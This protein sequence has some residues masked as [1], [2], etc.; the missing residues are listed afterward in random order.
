MQYNIKHS[1][2][3]ESGENMKR[4]TRKKEDGSYTFSQV[5]S[6][7]PLIMQKLGGMED[8]EEQGLLLRLPCKVGD[9][10]YGVIDNIY[11]F[12]VNLFYVYED[13][14]LIDLICKENNC[15]DWSLT[16]D[17]KNVGKRYFLTKE[18]AEQALAKMKEGVV[19]EENL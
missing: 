2:H 17:I 10:L 16:T 18:E 11:P 14:V 5:S 1:L 9:I 19:D 13:K 3:T 12:E 7:L 15:H 6:Q 4:L 8:A